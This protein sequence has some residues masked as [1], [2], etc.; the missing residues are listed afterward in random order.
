MKVGISFFSADDINDFENINDYFDFFKVPSVE[1]TNNLLINKLKDIG[2]KI[3][4]STGCQ[5]EKTILKQIK[6]L[7]PNNSILMHCIVI[8]L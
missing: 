2:E 7:N 6:N 5:D 3:I 4:F 1:F 8:T